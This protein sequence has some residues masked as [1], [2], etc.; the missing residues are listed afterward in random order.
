MQF[1]TAKQ[2][3]YKIPDIHRFGF[4]AVCAIKNSF[5]SISYAAE[6]MLHFVYCILYLQKTLVKCLLQLSCAYKIFCSFILSLSLNMLYFLKREI[7]ELREDKNSQSFRLKYLK[8]FSNLFMLTPCLRAIINHTRTFEVDKV[9][10]FTKHTNS[11]RKFPVQF[12]FMCI[13]DDN[14]SVHQTFH[15]F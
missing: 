8:F 9:S 13:P 7:A 2:H 5:F 6:N 12:H 4:D 14:Q 11:S 1:F 15:K 3:I 10:N